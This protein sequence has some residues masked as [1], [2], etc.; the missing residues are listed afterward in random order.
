M[1]RIRSFVGLAAIV[2]FVA[3]AS[4]AQA[5]TA[6]VLEQYG[7]GRLVRQAGNWASGTLFFCWPVV[8]RRQRHQQ[9]RNGNHRQRR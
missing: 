5:Q 2:L 4:L 3:T 6:C 7:L 1:S 8:R 9:W